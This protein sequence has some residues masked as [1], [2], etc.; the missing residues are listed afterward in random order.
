MEG[1][2]LGGGEVDLKGTVIAAPRNVA[3]SEALDGVDGGLGGA[4]VLADT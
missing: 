3:T 1:V 4:R 2:G